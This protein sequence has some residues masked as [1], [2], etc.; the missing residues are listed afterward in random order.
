M[1]KGEQADKVSSISRIR[2]I[3][4][5]LLIGHTTKDIILQGTTL[6][7][8]CDRQI[9]RYLKDARKW[10]IDE[11]KEKIEARRAFHVQARMRLF[12][13]L[14]NKDNSQGAFA[15][16]NLLKDIAEL[17]GLYIRK[18]EHTGKD[19]EPLMPNDPLKVSENKLVIA[20]VNATHSD[21]ITSTTE[22]SN[23]S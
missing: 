19:G 15:A 5:W 2:A 8:V 7:N 18:I 17:E 4:E 11:T 23:Q 16:L 12:K 14:K 13:N 6:W 10:F 3:Q 22:S 9:Y 20:V 1:N 21:T